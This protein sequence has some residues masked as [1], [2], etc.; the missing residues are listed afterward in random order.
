MPA[1]ADQ[2]AYIAKENGRNARGGIYGNR[3]T[4]KE[5][6]TRITS[7]IEGALAAGVVGLRTSV[8]QPLV[9][10]SQRKAEAT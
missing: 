5:N 4:S 3:D 10:G 8:D 7:D 2:C 9:F 1:V 6:V